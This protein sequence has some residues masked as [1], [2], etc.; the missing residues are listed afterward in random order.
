MLS[1]TNRQIP[2]HCFPVTIGTPI[3][4]GLFKADQYHLDDKLVYLY[5][6]TCK[7]LDEHKPDVL[8]YELP[9]FT[10]ACGNG[11][12]THQALGGT[13]GSLDCSGNI[14]GVASIQRGIV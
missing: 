14:V 1:P 4:Y 8:V 9:V 13:M 6:N 2:K 12:Y 5:N 7:L 11:S 10:K 3:S